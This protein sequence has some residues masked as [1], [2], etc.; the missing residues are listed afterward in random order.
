MPLP[1]DQKFLVRAPDGTYYVIR[2]DM[3]PHKVEKQAAAVKGIV[4]GAEAALKKLFDETEASLATGV[5][6]KFAEPPP[7]L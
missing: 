6:I 1:T 2:K 5:A 7:N 3:A 4:A